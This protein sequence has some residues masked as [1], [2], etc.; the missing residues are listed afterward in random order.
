MKRRR[1]LV[2]H[3]R[4]R[5]ADK[6]G[7]GAVVINLDWLEIESSP[8]KLEEILAVDQALSSLRQFDRQQAQ[9]V[10]MRYFAGMTVDETAAALGIAPR[11]V[12]REWVLAGAWLRR[13]LSGKGRA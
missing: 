1:V 7:G 9:I 6:R 4:T 2:D 5:L 3:A 12:D 11:T 10:E 8:Q 13:E